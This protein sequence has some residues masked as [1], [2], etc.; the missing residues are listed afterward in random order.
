MPSKY[1]IVSSIDQKENNKRLKKFL[2]K[3]VL[4]LLFVN[5]VILFGIYIILLIYG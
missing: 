1:Y 2:V 4:T 3:A 5:A